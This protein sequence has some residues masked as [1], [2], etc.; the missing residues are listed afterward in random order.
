V[1]I[2]CIHAPP[3]L[4]RSDCELRQNQL[5]R[6]RTPARVARGNGRRGLYVPETANALKPTASRYAFLSALDLLAALTAYSNPRETQERMG[7]IKY[8]LVNFGDGEAD[9]PLGD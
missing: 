4:S 1:E 6:L 9:G 2:R 5:R 3:A 8:A 7:R